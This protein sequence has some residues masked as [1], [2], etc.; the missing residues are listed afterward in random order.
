M[1]LSSSVMDDPSVK[2]ALKRP[3]HMTE[4]RDGLDAQVKA[5]AAMEA[6]VRGMDLAGRAAT[7]AAAA[8]SQGL[9]GPLN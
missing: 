5:L 9:K 8:P 7:E 1:E 2:S 3:E 6:H 4:E